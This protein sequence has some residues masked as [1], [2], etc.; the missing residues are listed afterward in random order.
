[1]I[2]KIPPCLFLSV[3]F[4]PLLTSLLRSLSLFTQILQF[5]RRKQ[6]L[7]WHHRPAETTSFAPPII[8]NTATVWALITHRVKPCHAIRSFPISRPNDRG[9]SRKQPTIATS[10]LGDV[11]V[12]CKL[13]FLTNLRLK[14]IRIRFPPIGMKISGPNLA[15][16]RVDNQPLI[17]RAR[18]LIPSHRTGRRRRRYSQRDQNSHA[19]TNQCTR[20]VYFCLHR[21]INNGCL[22]KDL[23]PAIP[24]LQDSLHPDRAHLD[25]ILE[26]TVPTPSPP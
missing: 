20:D 11:P 5:R 9:Q 26:I 21:F 15:S 1:M 23:K 17:P 18:N 7:R 13:L 8:Q 10:L 4:C 2:P 19:Q 16:H 14:E 12:V 24:N 25:T 22:P 6:K 3:I